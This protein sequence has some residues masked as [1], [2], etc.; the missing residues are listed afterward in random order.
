MPTKYAYLR[1]SRPEQE[2]ELQLSDIMAFY[3]GKDLII[4]QEQR[5]AWKENVKRPIFEGIVS[6]IKAGKVSDLYVWDLDRIHRNR[7]RLKEFFQLCKMKGTKIHSVN[8]KWLEELHS[9]PAPF[10]DIVLELLTSIFGWIGEEESTKKGARV[11]MAVVKSKDGITRSYKGSKWGRKRFPAQ[12]INR[13]LEMAVAGKS[14]REI[15]GEVKVYDKN[16]NEKS[17]SK[18]AVHKIIQENSGKNVR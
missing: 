7:L 15:A 8:Q 6:E 11:R 2:P 18:S 9:I 5:S 14:I 17:I 1:T 13:V 3:P 10:N 12:T 4:Q 16:R